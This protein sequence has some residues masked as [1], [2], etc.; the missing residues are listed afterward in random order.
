M[1]YAFYSYCKSI[2]QKQE[3]YCIISADPE[4]EEDMMHAMSC[5]VKKNGCCN[6]KNTQIALKADQFLMVTYCK[7]QSVGCTF[8]TSLIR[9][10]K[11]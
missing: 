4:I 9:R 6:F 2:M 1:F 8:K 11:S 10:K 5:G 3:N 7:I